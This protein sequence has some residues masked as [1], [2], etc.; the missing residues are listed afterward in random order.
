M[1]ER[2]SADRRDERARRDAA[3]VRDAEVDAKIA[4]S[5][6]EPTDSS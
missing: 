4:A 6:N 2:I 5:M 1:G 3:L